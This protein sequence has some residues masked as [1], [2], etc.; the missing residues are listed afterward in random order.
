MIMR[1]WHGVTLESKADDFFAYMMDTGV[2]MYKSID[3]NRGVYVLRR[4]K[5]GKA[6]FL[7]ISLWES[8]DAIRQFAGPDIDK[9]VYSFSKDKE[10]L[11]ELE[12]NVLHYEVLAGP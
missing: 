9:A 10:F 3:G 8:L 2:K 6:E 7:L 1:I 12:P 4:I 5:D 11:L